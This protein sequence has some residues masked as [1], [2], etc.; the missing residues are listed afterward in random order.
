M[1]NDV[2]AHFP[3][4]VLVTDDTSARTDPSSLVPY[5]VTKP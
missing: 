3:N 4:G 1:R 2:S 5:L